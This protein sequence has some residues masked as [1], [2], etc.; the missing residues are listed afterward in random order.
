MVTRSKFFRWILF[1]AFSITANSLNA[2]DIMNTEQTLSVKQQSII[3]I[4]AVTAKGYLPQLKTE[5]NKGLDAGLTVNQIKE[6]LVHLYAYC[7]FPR[8]LRGLMT[9]MEVLDDR[10]AKGI[11]D[12]LGA[13]ASPIKDD[14]SKYERGKEI[15]EKISGIKEVE[16]KRGY[17]AFAPEVEI[18]LKEHLFADL[19]ERDVLTYIERE[20]VTISVL[21][22]IGGVEPMLTGHLNIC[23]NIGIMPGQLQ[24]FI[25]VIQST[26]GKKEAKAA[27]TVLYDV[28]KN[29]QKNK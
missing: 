17:A 12:E 7:G 6:T 26:I 19:F 27:Q 29:N 14:R 18:F 16:P 24:Q 13:E 1:V 20:L 10:K 22:S 8:S 11:S 9:F 21:S 5:L 3:S 2:Q 25:G 28:L 15:L 4:A 23:L